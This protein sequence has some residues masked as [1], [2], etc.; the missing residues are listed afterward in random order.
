M[1]LSVMI[2]IIVWNY[3]CKKK[4]EK[5][6]KESYG[7]ATAVGGNKMTI[8]IKGNEKTPVLVLLPGWGCPSPILEFKPLADDLAKDFRIIT[9]EPFGYGLSDIKTGERTVEEIVDELHECICSLGCEK[10]YLVAHSIS[11]IYSLYWANQYPDEVEGFIGIDAS[12]P[13]QADE[14]EFPI[15]V[16]TLNKL[17]ANFQKIKNVLG[18]TRLQSIGKPENAVYAD[19]LYN[20]TDKEMEVFC[21][22]SID[23]RY[24]KGC[25]A[26][27]E[28]MERN[29]EKIR[30]MKFPDNMPVLEFI[31]KDNCETM[32]NWEILHREVLGDNERNEV[33]IIKGGHYLHLE[34]REKIVEKIREWIS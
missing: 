7:I 9:V 33:L 26:E 14:E 18:I 13:K 17:V 3:I 29:L 4:E 27:L 12:V 24:N 32:K 34:Q 22:L 23:R 6:L 8:D 16:I 20:Y 15:S 10:Y 5:Q 25:M 19:L 31:S 30:D 11:G 1:V 28:T 2:V 21:A